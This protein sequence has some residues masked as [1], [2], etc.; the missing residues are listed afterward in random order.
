MPRVSDGALLLQTM[1]ANAAAREGW[2]YI[3]NGSPLSSDWAQASEIRRWI[4]ETTGSCH[5][6]AARPAFLQ[7]PIFT[8]VWLLR[9]ETRLAGARDV[10]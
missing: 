8:Y 6:H 3:A 10:D 2:Q 1:L 9:N 5:R 4:L 7:H